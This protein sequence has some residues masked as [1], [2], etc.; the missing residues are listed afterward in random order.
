MFTDSIEAEF[1]SGQSGSIFSDKGL[2]MALP[3]M[4]AFDSHKVYLARNTS[5][6]SAILQELNLSS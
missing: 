2:H 5:A 3:D 4:P 1:H 6:G